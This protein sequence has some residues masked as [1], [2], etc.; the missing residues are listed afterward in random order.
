MLEVTLTELPRFVLFS[1]GDRCI[2]STIYILLVFTRMGGC[3]AGRGK[4]D[5]TSP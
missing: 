2:L 3:V 5:H 4:F 1:G